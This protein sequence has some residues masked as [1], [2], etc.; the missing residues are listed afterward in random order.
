VAIKGTA[1]V[2]SYSVRAEDG[3]PIE[4]DAAN[5]TIYVSKDGVDAVATNTPV[6]ATNKKGEYNIALTAAEN[7]GSSMSIFGR[8]STTGAILIPRKWTNVTAITIGPVVS[9]Y[10]P[11]N[12]VGAAV[13]L[14][15]FRAAT[16]SFTMT[17]LDSDDDPVD[18]SAASLRFVVHAATAAATELFTVNSP[19][20]TV[21]G[22]DDNVVT[23][24]VSAV[25]SAQDPDD[26][27]WRLWNITSGEVL[28]HGTFR[29]LAASAGTA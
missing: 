18:L 3:S 24:P 25:E 29:V 5:H 13:V 17:V 20:I 9:S 2:M 19:D 8:S 6:Q 16:K 23:V 12:A 27:Q 26:Y 1:I 14:E 7:N 15:M 4:D 10:N 11:G 21:A 28:L 22:A